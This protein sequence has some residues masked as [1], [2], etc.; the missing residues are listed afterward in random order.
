M[1]Y[2]LLL[3]F[4]VAVAPLRAQKIVP[5]DVPSRFFGNRAINVSL[6]AFYDKD[7]KKTYPLIVLLDGEYL[8]DPFNG[9]MSYT[10]Y[11]DDLPQAI[12]VGV[13]HESAEGRKLD[14]DVYQS[15]GLPQGQGDQYFQFIANE[16][17]PYMEKNY[18]IAASRVVAGH[19]LTAGFMN[20]F[21]YKEKP[22]FNAYISFSPILS[23]DMEI[24]TAE[25]L[26]AIKR[27]TYY[28]LATASGDVKKIKEKINTLNENIKA[29]ENPN[30][31]YKFEEFQGASHYSLVAHGIPEALYF[32]FADYQP[33]SSKEYEEKIV[34]MPSGYVDYL[35]AKYKT[36]REDLG[37]NIPVRLNDFKAIE[38]AIMKNAA[39]DELRDL[40]DMARDDY[41][42]MII[43]EY[44][45]GLH[46]EMK[47]ETRKAV[48][49]YLKGYNYAP[50]GDYTK[51]LIIEK[52]ESL[53]KL[54]E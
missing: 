3:I 47:G 12:I 39:Y 29:V 25:A 31:K 24:R 30:L 14:T 33:I 26:K 40:A 37:I 27:P 36:I 51:D 10:A 42:K 13:N 1:K 46:Y 38:A 32:I 44:F 11:W 23:T 48:R 4:F 35:K 28:F 8:L 6:P 43:G 17:I 45:E 18:R 20:F 53:K 7:E 21:L 9:I 15:T 41:P 16:L 34:T 54:T 5:D 22:V 19:N 49:A 50:I 2:K 52:A